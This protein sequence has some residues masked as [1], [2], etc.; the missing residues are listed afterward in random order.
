MERFWRNCFLKKLK[1]WTCLRKHTWNWLL[2]LDW[3]FGL[4][5]RY[6]WHCFWIKSEIFIRNLSSGICLRNNQGLYIGN[7]FDSLKASPREFVFS[8][9]GLCR[10]ILLEY[11]K[12]FRVFGICF[13]KYQGL[14]FGILFGIVELELSVSSIWICPL[15]LLLTCD[16]D[17]WSLCL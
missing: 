6:I 7:L 15:E 3:L 1:L 4:D 13:M 16:C 11:Y 17:L 2:K 9:Q 5:F 12:T 14:L 8:N 10:K